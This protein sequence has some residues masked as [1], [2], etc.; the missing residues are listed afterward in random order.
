MNKVD[1]LEEIKRTAAANGGIPLGRQKFFSETRIKQSDCLGVFWARWGDAVREAGFTP[2]Q[3]QGP[4]DKEE[5]LDKYAHFAKELGRI[6]TA[7]DLRLKARADAEFPTH[8]TW[9]NRFGTKQ[10]LVGQLAEYCRNRE[11][12]EHVVRWCEAY[13]PPNPDK[14]NGPEVPDEEFGFVY[15]L[16][17]GRFY[18]IGKTNAAGRRERE[19]VLQ[20][21]EKAKTVHVIR[22]DDPSGIEV[23]W[24]NRFGAKRKNGEWFELSAADIAA[25]KR[26]KFM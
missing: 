23:Y 25:F 4:H 8:T 15:L 1:I 6:P 13:Q 2:N 7:N 3:L 18:K 10:Q 26:R 5:L 9:S 21:P 17:S 14:P 22:T 24:H 12:Y 20:L 19:L 11:G 16:K